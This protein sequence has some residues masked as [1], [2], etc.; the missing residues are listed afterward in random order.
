M[1]KEL[2]RLEVAPPVPLT[3]F[4]E[5]EFLERLTAPEVKKEQRQPPAKARATESNLEGLA[6][7]RKAALLAELRQPEPEPELV[8]ETP[9]IQP[10]KRTRHAKP[11]PIAPQIPS[12]AVLRPKRN[13]LR[14]EPASLASRKQEVEKELNRLL[15]LVQ[16]LLVD[17][18]S[19][20][21]T[22]KLGLLHA[23]S[24]ELDRIENQMQHLRRRVI[25]KLET[26]A[27]KITSG[28]R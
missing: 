11:A 26:V 8:A 25:K 1:L 19:T 17:V 18:R 3:T 20:V 16:G 15:N 27:E 10:V 24:S 23:T 2:L 5:D 21:G 28:S 6:A 4:F 13:K 7:S 14:T 9:I 12:A 22:D